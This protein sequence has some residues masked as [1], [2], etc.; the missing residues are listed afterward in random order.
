MGQASKTSLVIGLIVVTAII[1]MV[2]WVA[3]QNQE[4]TAPTPLETPQTGTTPV[5][6]Q[7]VGEDITISAKDASDATIDQDLANLDKQMNYLNQDSSAVTE[8]L[9]ATTEPQ[10]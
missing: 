4:Q 6:Q 9:N 2:L 8:G 7:E 10:E 1:V 3:L 5:A